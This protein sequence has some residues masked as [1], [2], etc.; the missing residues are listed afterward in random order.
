MKLSEYVKGVHL[1]MKCTT[2]LIKG[3]VYGYQLI[4]NLDYTVK[5]VIF[6]NGNFYSEM[7]ATHSLVQIDVVKEKKTN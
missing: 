5:L 4:M 1:I 2:L 6:V 3:I 7:L